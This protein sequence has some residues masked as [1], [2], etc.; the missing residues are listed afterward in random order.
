MKIS[1]IMALFCLLSLW[2]CGTLR[3]EGFNTKH[4]TRL[5]GTQLHTLEA[6]SQSF[7]IIKDSTQ[8][9]VEVTLWPKGSFTYSANGFTGEASKVLIKGKTSQWLNQQNQ[10]MRSTKQSSQ[11][12]SRVITKSKQAVAIKE[13]KLPFLSLGKSAVMLLILILGY[14]VYHKRKWLAK[15]RDWFK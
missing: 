1:R 7:Q 6:Q 9:T 11:T 10:Q 5:S 8:A 14:I 12:K 4:T 3:K 15:I 2:S 13:K